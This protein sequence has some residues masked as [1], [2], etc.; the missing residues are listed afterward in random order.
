MNE[1]L[2]IEEYFDFFTSPKELAQSIYNILAGAE[3]N[4][5]YYV[6]LHFAENL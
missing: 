6:L 2:T 5:D 3:K 4:N 1:P